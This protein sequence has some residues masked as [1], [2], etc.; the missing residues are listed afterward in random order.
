MRTIGVV[1]VARSDYG[2]YLPMLRLIQADPELRLALFV[3][4]MH[5]SPEFGRTV[6]TIEEDGFEIAERIEM[7]VSSDTPQAIAKSTGLGL[8]GF[9]QAFVNSRPDILVVLGD[10]FE[11]MSAALAALPFKIPV[12]HIHG[13]E[14]T[15][16]AIDDALRHSITKLSHQHFVATER[17]GARVAQLGE[18]PSRISVFG[19]PGL[20]SI[21]TTELMSSAELAAKFNLTIEGK[22]LLVTFHPV[23]LEY[24]H[25]E[26]HISELLVA[27]DKAA[28]PVIFT[29]PNADTSGRVI[30]RAVNRFV[31]SHAEAQAVDN[32]GTRG[33]FSLM[34]V[35]SAM[36]GNSS[37]GIIEATSFQLPVVNIGT[38]QAGRDRARNVID[39]GY[40]RSAVLRGIRTAVS[41]EFRNGLR[42]L[43]N[44]YGRGDASK[45]IV[46]RLK[47][48]EL[49][50]E[51]I[52]KRFH[53]LPVS[54]SSAARPA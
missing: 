19:A 33:Y 32:L 27:L 45:R 49:N 21:G 14:V 6:Q 3:T 2:I 11:M 36:V 15:F 17:Y 37:S 54:A 26:R 44:P 4:G 39:V 18:F 5:L 46:D 1:T 34:S 47:T 20:D 43:K 7:L 25:T 30:I 38:R 52:V 41:T 13:G 31:E 9:A 48:V 40:E 51:L 12:A 10:R 23:T 16:G 28:L 35:A 53:D 8:I 42:G 24:E 50:Q 29:M 22:P